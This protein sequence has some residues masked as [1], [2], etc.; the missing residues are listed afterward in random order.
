MFAISADA[1]GVSRP[2]RSKEAIFAVASAVELLFVGIEMLQALELILAKGNQK[3]NLS[4]A[5]LLFVC[6]QQTHN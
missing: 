1:F 4:L 2:V 3:K 5:K 6:L